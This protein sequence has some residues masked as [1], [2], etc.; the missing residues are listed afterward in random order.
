MDMILVPGDI[1][2]CVAKLREAKDSWPI[3]KP[4]YQL[5]DKFKIAKYIS[6][7][8]RVTTR[9]NLPVFNS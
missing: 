3:M 8:I 4:V 1:H 7:H 9:I 2:V 6:T 5:I